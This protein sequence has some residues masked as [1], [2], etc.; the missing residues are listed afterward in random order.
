MD[1][2][3]EF[4]RRIRE[5]RLL[6]LAEFFRGEEFVM[7]HYGGLSIANLPATMAGLLGR[8][9]EAAE[10]PLPARAWSDLSGGVRRVVWVI[11]DA[12]G[13]RH[14]RRLLEA[15]DT[16]WSRLAQEGTLVPLTSIFPSTTMA[17]M[18]SFWTGRAPGGHGFLGRKLFLPEF[19]VLADMIRL[20][21]AT[22]GRPGSLLE[23]GWQPETF[24]PAPGLVQQLA[25]QGVETVA[26]LYAPHVG[27]GLAR[28]FLRG[29]SQVQGFIN[30]SDMWINVRDTLV[31]HRGEPLLVNA[32]WSGTDDVAHRY[33]PDD[34]RFQAAVRQMARSFDA[35]FWASLPRA[36][37]Q[38][39]V[40]IVIADHGQIETPPERAV[41]LGQHPALKEMLL[42]PPAAEPRASY[43]YVRRGQA[44]A[45]RAYVAEHLAEEFLLLDMD[46]AVAAGLFGPTEMSAALRARLGDAL[47][48]ARNDSRLIAEGAT[49]KQR[50]EHG[51]LSPEEMLVPL[52][53]ARLDG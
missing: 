19:G 35:D 25:A 50:G 33:G 44:E 37:R 24:L 43:L 49:A 29:V 53:M 11:L 6:E 47:L 41:H 40:L 8:K 21:L 18:S 2:A 22:R 17:A 16:V 13:Y 20:T 42:L 28:L 45:V 4:E 12:V 51:S 10:P 9:L 38:G 46:R 27:S 30:Y 34:E 26:H 14:F 36:A 5:H 1:L 39:T 48:L 23:W 32:Y 15:G 31:Q 3:A 7:P 52:L